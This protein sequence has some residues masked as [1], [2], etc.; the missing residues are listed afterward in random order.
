MRPQNLEMVKPYP[1]AQMDQIS[2]CSWDVKCGKILKQI[3]S[4]KV[5]AQDTCSS[6]EI[7]T[8]IDKDN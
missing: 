4:F 6:Y 1:L 2:Q 7:Q 5:F 8:L 3:L